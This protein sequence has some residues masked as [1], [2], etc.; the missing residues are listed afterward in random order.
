VFALPTTSTRRWAPAAFL[1]A[2]AMALVLSACGSDAS[3]TAS[4]GT[5]SPSSSTSTS[6]D[7]DAA[8]DAYDLKLAQ[9]MRDRGLDIKDPAPGV[10]ITESGPEVNAAASACMTKIG[11][12]PAH[13]FSDEEKKALQERLLKEAE[14]LRGLGYKVPDPVEGSLSLDHVS[15]ADFASCEQPVP[16]P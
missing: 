10:G 4:S 11:N 14:C 5:P 1:A 16:A 15:D 12:P 2:P 13:H 9:C 6:T 7:F 3:P 8:R